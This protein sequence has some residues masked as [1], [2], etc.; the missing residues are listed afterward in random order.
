[1]RPE[2]KGAR[3]G[4]G[5][6]DAGVKGGEPVYPPC[7]DNVVT[8]MEYA[9]ERGHAGSHDG[10]LPDRRYDIKFDQG[11]VSPEVHGT[12]GAGLGRNHPGQRGKFGG[13][14]QEG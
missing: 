2:G 12:H 1:M 10:N 6:Y 8:T 11:A 9:C 7:Y 13:E 5:S 3:A 14:R 4:K